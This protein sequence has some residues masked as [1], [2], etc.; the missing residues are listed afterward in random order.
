MG[1]LSDFFIATPDVA[2][3]YEGSGLPPQDVCSVGG[4]TPLEVAAIVGALRGVDDDVAIEDEL[5]SLA[6]GEEGPWLMSVPHDMVDLLVAIEDARVPELS[7]K[8]AGTVSEDGPLPDDTFEPMLGE[9][10]VLAR[11]AKATGKGLYFWM[12]L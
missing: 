7:A 6:G 1:L 4:I 12:S 10:V 8:I 11:R 9:L 5:E 3:A 2:R